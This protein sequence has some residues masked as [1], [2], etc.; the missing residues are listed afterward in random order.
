MTSAAAAPPSTAAVRS[1]PPLGGRLLAAYRGLWALLLVAAIA[2]LGRRVLGGMTEP[3]ILG[4]RL[5]KAAVLLTVSTIL[6]RRRQSDSVAAMLSLAFLLWA[7]TSSFDFAA[8]GS[9]WLPAL[10]RLRFLLFALALLV[11]PHG[12]WSPDWTRQVA[13]ASLAVCLEGLAEAVGLLP[14]RLFLPFAIACVL[15]AVGA[16]LTRYR[17]LG[18]TAEKQQLKWVALGLTAGIGLILAARAGDALMT[19]LPPALLEGLFQAGIVIIAL[20][21]LVSLLRYRLYDAETVISRSAAYALLT[22][23]L[24]AT[25]AGSEALIEMLGQQYFGAGIGNIS[26]AMAAAVAAVLLTP[27]NS[28]ITAWA[29]RHFQRDLLILK[30]HLPELLAE[31]SASAS[32]VRV[33]E[34][35]LPRIDEAVHAARAALVLGGELVAA[36]QVPR[37]RAEHWLG[38]WQAPLA[39]GPFSRN[40]SD[41]WF[42][43]RMALTCPFGTIHGWLLLGPRPDGSFYGKDDLDALLAIAPPLR[44]TLVAVRTREQE[45]ALE[46]A[47]RRKLERRID[48][49]AARVDR[50]RPISA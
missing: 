26:G 25:F 44:R 45:L 28:R 15:A 32:V 34:A 24:V 46:A 29:E 37:R 21:F 22:L 13:L 27:L 6:F 9:W 40:L 4:L 47:H 39:A 10:D 14:T 1:L 43:L 19:P 30:E 2:V 23:S 50:D 8:T 12:E 48:Q 16:L 38:R 7:I 49:L 35:V 17:R 3:A 42:P 36:W 11:F 5:V 33:G 20:G 41:P 31:L 18:E